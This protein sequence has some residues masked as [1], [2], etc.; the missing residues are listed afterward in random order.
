MPRKSELLAA[1]ADKAAKQREREAKKAE[2]E[3][4]RQEKAEEKGKQAEMATG[5]AHS[6]N[7]PPKFVK[8]TAE[9]DGKT[10]NEDAPTSSIKGAEPFKPSGPC[11]LLRLDENSLAHCMSFFTAR[12]LGALM[13]ASRYF[14][15]ETVGKMMLKHVVNQTRNL[16]A[17]EVDEFERAEEMCR[18]GLDSGKNLIEK[19]LAKLRKKVERAANAKGVPIDPSRPFLTSSSLTFPSYARFLEEAIQLHTPLRVGGEADSLTLPKYTNG[20]FASVSPE[21]TVIRAGGGGRKGGGSGA[22]TFGV[23]RRGQLGHGNREDLMYPKLLGGGVGHAVRVIQVAAGGGLV[24]VAH[25]LLLTDT[26]RVLAFGTAGYGQL[27][28]GFSAG[29]QVRRD[30]ERRIGGAK[31]GRS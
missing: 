1:A 5:L 8:K 23:G 7:I 17:L 30:E 3:R 14:A 9:S 21:H 22:L 28:H 10:E 2:R 15:T 24:R 31:D 6:G 20:R 25:T 4:R 16:R 27:G 19:E 18:R 11:H 12:T 26:G 13:I 29:K